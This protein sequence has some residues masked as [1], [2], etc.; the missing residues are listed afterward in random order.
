MTFWKY[1]ESIFLPRT[2]A[3]FG[4]PVRLEIQFQVQIPFNLK[5]YVSLEREGQVWS[6]LGKEIAMY[7]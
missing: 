5:P 7:N 4:E 6:V 2:G 3:P 1:A